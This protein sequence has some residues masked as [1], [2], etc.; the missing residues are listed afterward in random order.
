MLI[1]YF[2]EAL[3]R[4]GKLFSTP[5]PRIQV[6]LEIETPMGQGQDGIYLSVYLYIVDK[7]SPACTVSGPPMY[8]YT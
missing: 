4:Q 2:K 1:I 3:I 8:V 7:N 5:L 6:F